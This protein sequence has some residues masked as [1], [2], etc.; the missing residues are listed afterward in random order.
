[1]R[2]KKECV[3]QE[4]RKTCIFSETKTHY[5]ISHLTMKWITKGIQKLNFTPRSINDHKVLMTVFDFNKNE[6]L[7]VQKNN[8]RCLIYTWYFFL[9]KI[10]LTRS[11]P[12]YLLTLSTT[13]SLF[14]SASLWLSLYWPYLRCTSELKEVSKY[15]LRPS[16]HLRFVRDSMQSM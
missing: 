7:H 8:V 6:Y 1:M 12:I 9:I 10:T 2:L 16:L 11:C 3:W 4:I 13:W 15:T 14:L 5:V